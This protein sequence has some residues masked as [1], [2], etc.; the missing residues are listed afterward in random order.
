MEWLLFL[1]PAFL[2]PLSEP[3]Y[4]LQ[5]PHLVVGSVFLVLAS[6]GSNGQAGKHKDRHS[7]QE[8]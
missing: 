2:S 7:E 6:G 1:P 5:W 8:L 3:P 4:S